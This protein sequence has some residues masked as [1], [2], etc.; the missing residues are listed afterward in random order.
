MAP[1]VIFNGIPEFNV[2][3]PFSVI[4]PVPLIITPPAQVFAVKVEGHSVETVRAELPALYWS[5]AEAP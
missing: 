1:D 3:A 4:A 5:V 2:L